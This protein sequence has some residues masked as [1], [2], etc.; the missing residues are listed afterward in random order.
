[1]AEE[2]RGLSV[3]F[4][5]DFSEFKK[6]L[7][8]AD[9]DINTTQKQL[10]LLQDSLKIEWDAKKF[11]QAQQ[12]AQKALEATQEKANLLRK[13][14]AAMEQAGVTDKTRDEYNYLQEQ[15]ARTELSAQRLGQQL[16]QLEEMRLDNLTSGIDEFSSKLDEAADATQGL[17]A[18][19]AAALVGL[20]ALGLEAVAQADDIATLATKYDMSTDALQRFNYVALQ[21]DTAAEDL[22]KAFVK[23]QGGVSD[24]SVGASSVATKALSQ[25]GL[26]F[27]QFSG[28]E[29]QFYAIIDALSNMED[30]AKM[31]SLANDIFGEKMAT[32]LFPLIYAGTD[33]VNEYKQEFEDL[34]YL[35]EDQVSQLAEFDNVLNK[36]KEQY[37]NV[38]LQ[39]G[40]SLLP[41]LESF[42]KFLSEEILPV[43][44]EFVDRFAKMDDKTKNFLFTLLLLMSTISPALRLFSSLGTSISTLV[45]KLGQLDAAALKTYAS[46]GLLFASIAM[47]FYLLANWSNMNPVQK[48]VG[49]L[50]A[51]TAVALS[52]AI[53]MGAFHSAATYGLAAAGIVAGITAVI[54]AVESARD[55]TEA[56]VQS[57][58]SSSSYGSIDIPTYTIPSEYPSSDNYTTNTS[59]YVDNSNVVIN[60]EK[61]ESMTEEDIVKAVN[62][63]LKKAKQART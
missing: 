37:K 50:G 62:K 63:G 34:G 44:K 55:A 25:L 18:A 1:M 36:L 35:T 23:V 48:I 43:L 16:K 2:I 15:L 10:K 54:A 56:D 21:T 20:T 14:L 24:L 3:K 58:S 61:H 38:A 40:S 5:A 28:A 52:A 60:I 59:N 33:A 9:K 11:T 29:E 45:R 13:R 49:L 47:L 51:L 53:A 57:S 30:Q 22:Y 7:K 27:E 26:S 17:S 32:N 8:S 31:V 19:S 4:D 6:G 41:V 12:Q 42:S 39:L 46:W